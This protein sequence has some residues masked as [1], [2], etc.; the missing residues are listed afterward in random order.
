MRE[1]DPERVRVSVD[2][3][4][5]EALAEVEGDRALLEPAKRHRR[6]ERGEVA[7]P[8]HEGQDPGDGRDAGVRRS[9]TGGG[10]R[11]R[12]RNQDRDGEA[13]RRRG[14][15]PQTRPGIADAVAGGP[16]EQERR[17]RLDGEEVADDEERDRRVATRPDPDPD[18]RRP[19]PDQGRDRQ[20]AGD[21][22][23]MGR[24]SQRQIRL[25]EQDH[26]GHLVDR[27]RDARDE[28]GH[29][30]DREQGDHG[31][32]DQHQV[33]MDRSRVP[34]VM[35]Q[36]HDEDQD[37]RRLQSDIDGVHESLG[38]APRGWD[39]IDRTLLAGTSASTA[40]VRPSLT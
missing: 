8:G 34:Q 13:D 27:P 32:E 33:A 37:E 17:D 39:R 38:T 40:D 28:T 2:R 31:C 30:R 36:D 10:G 29:D 11:S 7:Q 4:S 9:A 3:R 22:D 15:D 6:D 25:E 35:D 18:D 20:P 19:E 5:E 16:E 14:G 24:E 12:S 26:P 23:E 1:S 21:P